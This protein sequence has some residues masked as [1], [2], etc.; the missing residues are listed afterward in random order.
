MKVLIALLFTLSLP[1]VGAPMKIK[2]SSVSFEA[3]GNP[4]FLT[5]EGKGGKLKADKL[6]TDGTHIWGTITVD[7]AD[8][9]T[10]MDLRNDHMRDK[11]LLISKYPQA[12]LVLEK[13]AMTARTFKGKLTIKKDTQK[14]SGKFSL[15]GA[16]LTAGLQINLGDYPSVGTPSWKG[17]SLTDEVSI[18]VSATLSP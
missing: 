3:T 12:K 4:G 17:I 5:V 14:V 16:K 6:E 8:L 18:S 9:D 11:Y 10:D 1:L 13:T 15:K 2:T 7:L